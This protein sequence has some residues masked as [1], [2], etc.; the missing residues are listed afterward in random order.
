MVSLRLNCRGL[1]V[2][3][4]FDF[5]ETSTASEGETA[6]FCAL[7]GVAPGYSGTLKVI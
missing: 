1:S 5:S 3:L 7:G 2:V 6:A 4:D